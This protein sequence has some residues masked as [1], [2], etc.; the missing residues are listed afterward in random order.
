M[1][2]VSLWVWVAR[3]AQS[4]QNSKFAISLQQPKENVKVEA[5][6]LAIDKRQV[7]SNWYYHFRCVQPAR[8]AYITQSNNFVISLQ[9]LKKEVSDE[10]VFL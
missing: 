2:V 4:T 10:V 8:H 3:H 1:S 9:Y 5:D 6:L 7:S